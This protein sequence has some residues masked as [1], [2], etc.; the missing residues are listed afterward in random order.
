MIAP[1]RIV[2]ADDHAMIR[3]AIV[4]FLQDYINEVFIVGEAADGEEL[5]KVLNSQK[6]DMVLLD[7]NMPVMNG[8]KALEVIRKRFPDLKIIVI[9]SDFSPFLL[10]SYFKKGVHGY[11]PKGC[12]IEVLVRAILEVQKNGN[13]FSISKSLIKTKTTPYKN[14]YKLT[15]KEMKVLSLTSKGHSNREIGGF[16]EVSESAIEYHKTNIY[17]K[18]GLKSLADLISYGIKNGLDNL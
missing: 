14:P 3:Q 9:S 13:C 18:T 12:D 6:A 10:E 17:H 8:A 4:S 11:I 2:I 1:V 15:P 5:L 16:L 7:L